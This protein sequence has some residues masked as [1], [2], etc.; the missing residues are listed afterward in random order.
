[1]RNV[2]NWAKGKALQNDF[3][4]GLEKRTIQLFWQEMRCLL[5]FPVEV[6]FCVYGTRHGK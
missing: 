6:Y 4:N 3:S 5:R 1:M 2:P